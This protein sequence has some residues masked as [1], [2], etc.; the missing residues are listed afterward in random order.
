MQLL[1]FVFDR[2]AGFTSGESWRWKAFKGKNAL[3]PKQQN[4]A[5]NR[6]QLLARRT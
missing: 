5:K 1:R 4:E 6:S 3:Q 2:R